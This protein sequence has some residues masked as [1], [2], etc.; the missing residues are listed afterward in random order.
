MPTQ[1]ETATNNSAI[2]NAVDGKMAELNSLLVRL[3]DLAAKHSVLS[4][5]VAA[6]KQ[7]EIGHLR[8]DSAE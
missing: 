7:E 2:L 1:T 5:S 6:F 4:E 8:N 3:D